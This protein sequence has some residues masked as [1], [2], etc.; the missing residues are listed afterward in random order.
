MPVFGGK[1]FVGFLIHIIRGDDIHKGAALDLLWMIHDHPVQYPGATVMAGHME[2][3]KTQCL[4]HFHLVICQSPLGIIGMVRQA[5]RLATVPIAPQIGDHDGVMLG[6]FRGQEP[7]HQV[8][9]RMPVNEQDGFVP[10]AADE[11]VNY[12]TGFCF[13]PLLRESGKILLVNRHCGSSSSCNSTFQLIGLLYYKYPTSGHFC[14]ILFFN[15]LIAFCYKRIY[16]I[17]I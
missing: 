10:A 11:C 1:L 6:Q 12:Y 8:R 9:F 5:F 7:P 3:L 16:N 2:P 15:N 4:H 14:K 13:D 17:F